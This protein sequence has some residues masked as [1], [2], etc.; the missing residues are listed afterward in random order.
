[1]G[2]CTMH[3]VRATSPAALKSCGA[4]EG[5]GGATGDCLS[6]CGGGAIDAGCVCTAGA[7]TAPTSESSG[8]LTLAEV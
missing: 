1:M 8:S 6:A 4:R 7:A 5:R 2:V 3:R